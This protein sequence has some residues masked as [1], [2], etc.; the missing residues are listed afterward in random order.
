MSLVICAVIIICTGFNQAAYSAEQ[1]PWS[2]GTTILEYCT[3]AADMLKSDWIEN[4]I[5]EPRPLPSK[6]QQHKA[7]QCLCYV[8]GFKDALYVNQIYQEKNG[9]HSP[10][11]IPDNNIAN[12]KALRVVLKYLSNNPQLLDRPGS[13]LLFSAFFYAFP[14]RESTNK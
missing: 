5:K 3:L 10:I 8:I 13:V 1:E 14:Y 7:M 11:C 4:F 6:V 9:K 12:D 2:N